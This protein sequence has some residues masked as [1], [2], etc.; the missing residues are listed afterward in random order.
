MMKVRILKIAGFILL[1]FLVYIVVC[2]VVPPL[3]HK[4]AD[5]NKIICEETDT[6]AGERILCI[7]D[8]QEALIWRLRIIEAAREEIVLSTFD[9]REDNSGQDIMAALHHAA[10]RGVKIRI[11]VDGIPGTFYLGR[12]RPFH[13]LA[14]HPNIEIQ[15]YNP[16]NL[17]TPWEFNYRMHDKYLMAD[18]MVYILG[19]RNT[20]DLFL[21][22]YQE[23]YNADRDILVWPGE[24]GSSIGAL[25]EYFTEIW[26]LSCNKLLTYQREDYKA[27]EEKLRK[28]YGKLLRDYPEAFCEVDWQE[29]TLE[30]RSIFLLS[31]SIKPENK[32]PE[33]WEQLCQLMGQGKQIVIETPYI[34]CDDAM[35]QDLTGLCD[36]GRQIQIV[37]NA[38]ESGAN[39]FGCTD[40]LNQKDNILHT[41]SEIYELINGQSLHTK[42]I[43]IDDTV[44]VIGSYNLDMR[45][46]YLDTE[47]MLMIDCPELNAM[48][49]ETVAAEMN[50]SRHIMPDGA[51]EQGIHFQAVEMPFIRRFCTGVLRVILVP[52][53]H[54]L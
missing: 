18:N 20:N 19:G 2:G 3:F 22:E 48:L 26:S 7:D 37:V 35:Y 23:E 29:E 36:G 16:I 25:K 8:N 9:F 11:L 15:I 43:L 10:E 44:S 21:G 24:N 5:V 38:V 1:L 12:S 13:A 46:T 50:M 40:Y 30:T 6:G 33:L 28:H 39:P 41:G 54:L 17:F 14:S 51:E 34:I 52:F 49:R 31:N 47:L 45:S 27:E 4:E 53:R 42:T 32:E